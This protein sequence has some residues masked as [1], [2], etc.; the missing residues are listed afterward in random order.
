M[1]KHKVLNALAA[2]RKEISGVRYD[3]GDLSG[4]LNIDAAIITELGVLAADGIMDDTINIGGALVP[5]EKIQLPDNGSAPAE[6]LFHTKKLKGALYY[7]SGKEFIQDNQLAVPGVP[8]LIHE[9]DYCSEDESTNPNMLRHQSVIDFISLLG[10]IADFKKEDFGELELVFFQKKKLSVVIKYGVGNLGKMN[11]LADLAEQLN[12][13]HDRFERIS[14]F[15]TE[16]VLQLLDI[17]EDTRFQTLLSRFDLVYDNYLNSHLLYLEKFSY[18]DLK[19][20]VDKDKLDYTKRIYATVN[21]IQSKLIALPA[22]FLLI[23]SQFDFSGAA[24]GKNLLILIASVIFSALL[25]ILLQ[26]Q[27]GVLEYI[28]TEINHFTN[29]LRNKDTIVDLTEILKSFGDLD[30][31]MDKQKIYLWI[32]RGAVWLV[33]LITSV[34][35]FTY[36]K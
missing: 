11:R 29:Q 28:K 3:K 27:F 15:K 4:Q 31:N 32:F 14:I 25:E 10:E 34:L 12:S 33:P 35:F 23:F 5:V 7:E 2:I 18:H 17:D 36:Q 20:A 21:D 8:F 9:W 16:L 19:S 24:A 13:T 26:N 22:A 6:I 1:M 30:D